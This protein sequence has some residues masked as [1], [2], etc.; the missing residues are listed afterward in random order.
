M[1]YILSMIGTFFRG[2]FWT[3]GRDAANE[4]ADKVKDDLNQ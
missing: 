3:L 4:V 1:N 2:F